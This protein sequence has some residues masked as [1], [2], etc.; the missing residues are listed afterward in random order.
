MSKLRIKD[1]GPIKEG[2]QENDG[3]L[4]V[5]KVTVFIGN[6]GSGKSTVAKLISTLSWIE[7]AM[8][9]GTIRQD[10]L[11]THNRFLKQLAY[12]RIEKY[13]KAETS[14]EYIGKAFTLSYINGKFEAQKSIENG[15][16]LPK[17][18][19]APA[20]RNFLSSVDRPDKLKNLPSTLY[21]FNDEFD[22]A[23]NLFAS[24]IELPINKVRFE[25]DKLNKLARIVGESRSY[26]LR[27][28]EAS[29]GFQSTVPLFLVTK[30]L[31]DSLSAE[32]DPSIKENSLEEQKKLD[33]EIKAIL[34]DPQLTHEIRQAYLRQL[35]AKR[36]RA[37]F[38]NIV[39]EPEQN[40][41]PSSQRS[42]LFELLSHTKKDGNKLI[43]TTHSPY[44]INYLTLSVEAY[45]LKSRVNTDEL[46]EK[47]NKIVPLDSTLNGDDLV[48]Y[49]LNEKNGQI[50]KLKTYKGLPSDENYLNKGLAESNDEFSKLLDIEDLCQ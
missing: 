7:K 49:E 16:L 6:Q 19:Y 47:L 22:S 35:S 11:N 9:M 45:K 43:M 12:Q 41:F 4:D 14:I 10:E 36:K 15:Y 13:A 2:Y 27:L 5:K 20:E 39:E 38:I 31:S 28:S 25:Y 37:C 26:E 1:F 32:E 3:W 24:G 17:I 34:N 50:T 42:L 46:R 33:K 48:V 23:K 29:S 8:V 21:T 18:M 44:L 40:L 30:Y